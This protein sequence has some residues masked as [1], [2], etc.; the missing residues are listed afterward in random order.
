MTRT[1]RFFTATAMTGIIFACLLSNGVEA[2]ENA[3][4]A[5]GSITGGKPNA[6]AFTNGELIVNCAA[7][8]DEYPTGISYKNQKIAGVSDGFNIKLTVPA[9]VIIDT[10]KTATSGTQSSGI[11]VTAVSKRDGTVTITNN[12]KITSDR[13][14]IQA[15]SWRDVKVTNAGTLNGG[16]GSGIFARN[17]G[18]GEI[19]ITH[20]GK[21]VGTNEAGIYAWYTGTTANAPQDSKNRIVIRSSGD[22]TVEND[23]KTAR[24]GILAHGANARQDITIDIHVT[25][26]T[27]RTDDDGINA[28]T[29]GPKAGAGDGSG[30]IKIVVDKGVKIHSN[31]ED[32]ITASAKNESANSKDKIY[33]KSDAEITS[34][35]IGIYAQ[36]F[37]QSSDGQIT[38]ISGGNIKTTGYLRRDSNDKEYEYTNFRG[39]ADPDAETKV[40]SH[41]IY[42]YASHKSGA[43]PI[44]IDITG[45]SIVSTGDGVHVRNQ[46]T[47]TTDVHVAS[48]TQ[49]NAQGFGIRIIGKGRVEIESGARVHGDMGAVSVNG[50]AAS[51]YLAM[52][53]TL[54]KATPRLPT[55]SRYGAGP[56]ID[57]DT[58]SGSAMAAGMA[59]DYS[60]TGL[61]AGYAMVSGTSLWVGGAIQYLPMSTKLPA[62]EKLKGKGTG[63][64]L[65]V[66]YRGSGPYLNG[67][68]GWTKFKSDFHKFGSAGVAKDIKA[69]QLYFGFEGGYRMA[70]NERWELTPRLTYQ[71]VNVRPKSFSDSHEIDMPDASETSLGLGMVASTTLK[72]DADNDMKGYLSLDFERH[73]FSN[74][75]SYRFTDTND[76]E[77]VFDIADSKASSMLKA[78]VGMDWK[79]GPDKQN[80]LGAY[81][82]YADGV[83]S[84][85]ADE[86]MGGVNFH[87]Q[88]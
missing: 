40:N 18:Y 84:S 41:G 50:V 20:S 39:V 45:G 72:A 51:G 34:F 30:T 13:I 17:R 73:S 2:A 57:L 52:P 43:I 25:G 36:H 22:I 62:G 55:L 58:R 24:H 42:A 75:G 61:S 46:G 12:G 85:D 60:S 16:D 9:G 48:G 47:G 68:L 6:S 66:E 7:D 19:H 26:G 15:T 1:L 80:T 44:D 11:S 49:I 74:G 79:F 27:I 86:V 81:L 33:I 35:G 31:T 54:L 83:S 63:L 21:I 38:I 59:Y 53:S 76:D 87:W 8:N 3:C 14:A 88:F 82:G 37:G 69:T 67:Q 78:Q 64:A 65:T 70:W 10:T 23:D 28:N 32:G 4:T 5:S 29:N 71:Y 56:W 77:T